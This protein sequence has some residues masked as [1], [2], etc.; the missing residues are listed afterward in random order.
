M[1][2]I[3]STP[4]WAA[5]S[6]DAAL[7]M[8]SAAARTHRTQLGCVRD[9]YWGIPSQSC[10]YEPNDDC[11][12]IVEV[13]C[14]GPEDCPAAMKCCTLHDAPGG[15]F[16][17]AC[18]PSCGYW[19][20]LCHAGQTCETP[21]AAGGPPDMGTCHVNSQNLG[22][23]TDWPV[24]FLAECPGGF[25]DSATPVQASTAAGEVNCGDTVCGAGTKCCLR[26]PHASY[27]TPADTPCTCKG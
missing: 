10:S 4:R 16:A 7:A 14:D 19:S 12:D 20:E 11:T 21:N 18:R 3:R 1:R 8:G 22:N 9:S 13:A 27:C 5:A 26:P 17:S 25:P 2:A 23:S 24:P 15:V 6:S